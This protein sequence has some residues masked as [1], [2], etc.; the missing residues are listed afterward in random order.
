MLEGS[1]GESKQGVVPVSDTDEP[2]NPW[3]YDSMVA[4]DPQASV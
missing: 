2:D 3:E 1:H 4:R